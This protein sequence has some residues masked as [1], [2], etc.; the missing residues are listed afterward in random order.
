MRIVTLLI[1]LSTFVSA[2]IKPE[3]IKPGAE[4]LFE[5]PKFGNSWRSKGKSKI[6][7]KFLLPQNFDKNRKHPLILALG[8]GYGGPD[9][10]KRWNAIMKG[11]HFIF[12]GVDYDVSGYDSGFRI[13]S[14]GLKILEQHVEVD[15]ERMTVTGFSSG[16]YSICRNYDSSFG[17]QFLCYIPM[18]GGGPVDSGA[19]R[20]KHWLWVCGDKDL[21]KFSDGHSRISAAKLGNQRLQKSK[22]DSTMIVM[23]DVG[24]SWSRDYD[25]QIKEW[26]FDK[27]INPPL[28][29]H[30]SNALAHEKAKRYSK[31]LEE[32]A[33]VTDFN[34]KESVAK[35]KA[36]RDAYDIPFRDAIES[37]EK[38]N[39]FYK[40]A[41]TFKALLDKYKKPMAL[42]CEQK[43]KEMKKN[44]VAVKDLRARPYFLKIEK[45]FKSGKVSNDKI[46]EALNKVLT[47]APD[48]KSAALAEELMKDL[49]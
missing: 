16:A 30:Y 11:K 5:L 48:T 4:I 33:Y 15:R 38:E 34:F 26:V 29:L 40:A 28:E 8:G 17:K 13:A 19:N 22:V 9:A 20:K 43:L 21:Q 42:E 47:L 18:G 25:N 12:M 46:E 23:K 3:Q 49:E 37:I 44:P 2:Q 31:A 41:I 36:I 1:M 14:E 7:V 35:A 39:D 27:I 6:Q 24:H 45:A 32:F 10:C